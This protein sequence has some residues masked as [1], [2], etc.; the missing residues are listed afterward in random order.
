MIQKKDKNTL[1]HVFLY[2]NNQL[3]NQ[4]K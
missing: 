1:N 2:P 4:L 3:K